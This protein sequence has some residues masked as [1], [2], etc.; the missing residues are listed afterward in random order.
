M[1]TLLLTLLISTSLIGTSQALT[2]TNSSSSSNANSQKSSINIDIEQFDGIVLADEAKKMFDEHVQQSELLKVSLPSDNRVIK[3]YRRYQDYRKNMLANYFDDTFKYDNGQLLT[4]DACMKILAE[5]KVPTTGAKEKEDFNKCSRSFSDYAV[6]NFDDGILLYKELILK[7]VT[8]KKD[9]WTYKNSGKDDFNPRDYQLWGTLAPITMFYAVNYEELN[10]TKDENK[11]IQQYLKNKAMI[12]RLDRD[13]N[14]SRRNLCP[15]TD[16]MKLNRKKHKVN[17]CGSVRLRFAAAELALAIVMQDKELWAKGLWDLDYTLSMIEKEGFF[18][19]LSAKGCK[20]LGYTWDTSK[21]FSLNVEMLKLADFDLLDYK[22]RHGKTIAEAYEMLFK[23]YKDIT[24][25]NH[26]AKKG[27]GA[28][29]CG[30]YKT[31]EEFLM[32]EEGVDNPAKLAEAYE[33]GYVPVHEDYINW[34]IRFVS[35][36]HPEW[37]KDKYT[38]RDIKVYRTMSTYYFVQAI[39]IFNANIMSESN[40]IWQEKFKQLELEAKKESA[41]C[42]VSPLNGSEYVAKWYYAIPEDNWKHEYKGKDR[43]TLDNCKGEIHISEEFWP[44]SSDRKNIKI[45]WKTNGQ[46]TISGKLRYWPSGESSYTLLKGSIK[47]GKISGK[48]SFG[49]KVIIEIISQKEIKQKQIEAASELSI[50]EFDGES[51]NLT[52]DKV[53]FIETRPFELER[54]AEYL[55]PYQLHKAV[56]D[57][58]LRTGKHWHYQF[59]TLVYKYDDTE[60]QKLVIHVD[61]R[62]IKPLKRHKDSLEKKCGPQRRLEWGWLNFISKTNDINNAK[63]QQ[64]IYDYFKEANDDS[65][66]ELFQAI[67]GGTDSILDYLQTNVEI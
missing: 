38:L 37:L 34:S 19:P 15:I 46:I 9:K 8:A 24:I 36:K 2:F 52:L 12:E 33:M 32:Q 67:L 26:I 3:D 13:G 61:D 4:K 35:E 7:I 22:T 30:A 50:F 58:R 66:F 59:L 41:A 29:S 62:T 57:G 5:F 11:K 60:E 63:N 42:K 53:D 10:Y 1:K 64:C 17:N 14:R 20:A 65:A 40:S 6:V 25:S 54:K 31:H 39:E 49:D 16:P 55:K 56:I 43:L 28:G 47:S 51:F 48:N 21:L 23:Q 45:K 18:V 44:S 27:V